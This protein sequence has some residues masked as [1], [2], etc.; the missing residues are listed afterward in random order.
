MDDEIVGAQPRRWPEAR[1]LLERLARV[2]ED[3]GARLCFRFREASA[4]ASRADGLL[5]VLTE[6]GHEVGVHSH[7]RRL[8]EAVAA[9]RGAGVEPVSA[10][11]GLVQVGRSGRAPLL[12]QVASLGIGLVTD[13]G[14][15]SAW[16]YDGLLPRT[17]QGVLVMAPTVRPFDWGLMERDGTRHGLGPGQVQR[18]RQL[19]GMARDQGA[20]WFGA[21]LH[22]HDLCP[23]GS[24]EPAEACLD[25][26]A[27]YLDPR[28]GPAAP[29]AIPA[30]RDPPGRPIADRSVRMRRLTG[31]LHR[32]V[33]GALPTVAPRRGRVERGGRRMELSVDGRRVVVQRYGPARPKAACVL[34]HAGQEGGRRLGLG[35]FGTAAG[36]LVLRG[37][38]V[39]SYDRAGTGDSAPAADARLTPGNP[40][41]DADWRAVLGQ[42]R[43]DGCPRVALT[44]SGGLVAALR[45]AARG[46]RPEALVDGA[47]PADRWSLVPPA[48]N[49]L[50]SRDPW[51]DVAWDGIEARTLLP[52]LAVPYARLQAE[53]DHLHGT[54]TH[55]ARRMDEAAAAAGL[56]SRP[57][58][59]VEGDLRDHPLELVDAL[60]WSLRQVR[61]W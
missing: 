57:L 33:R 39:W 37:W 47:G 21:A 19:E 52:S 8:A 16:A 61:G 5:P 18:L 23:P 32:R 26:L 2:A 36:D 15:G 3:R 34:C 27:T 31:G 13:H 44:W 49:E 54:M 9:V 29:L 4:L 48:G 60:Q 22:E 56:L 12:R 40:A 7:G 35:P 17:E 55:H 45:A 10:V 50:S 20:A 59:V 58:R 53:R 46:D 6:R 14:A 38:S 43:A 25:A 42:A 1:A 41:H 30:P 11:P 24:L 28:V 51:D